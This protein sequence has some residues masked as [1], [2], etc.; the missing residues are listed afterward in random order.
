MRLILSIFFFFTLASSAVGQLNIK[1]GF[2]LAYT[3]ADQ[4][5]LILNAFNEANAGMLE[6]N[7]TDL[8]TLQGLVVGAQYKMGRN[9]IELSWE[10]LSTKR[11][12]VGET[13]LMTLFQQELFYSFNQILFNF[14]RSFGMF[15]LGGGLG[16]NKVTVRDKISTSE[17]KKTIVSD[18]QAVAR[19]S[20]SFNFSEAQRVSF[21]VK[22]YI[23]I[24]LSDID[25]SNLATELEVDQTVYEP[26]SF[27]MIGVALIFYNG[28]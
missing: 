20:L 6:K 16:F 10:H 9:A 19:F 21:A 11:E 23:Q 27:P 17:V 18:R 13:M 25:L 1:V 12:G 2:G 22:P 15:G 14:E 7:L 5:N 3:S 4:N 28:R 8:G 26:E 24:P